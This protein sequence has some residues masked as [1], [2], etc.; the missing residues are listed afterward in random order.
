MLETILEIAKFLIPSLIV[1]ATAYYLLNS[2]LENQLKLRQVEA[3]MKKSD[4]V[5]GQVLPI[6]L[7]AYERLVCLLYTSDA[8]DE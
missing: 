7:Q 3:Q 8:A 2:Y 1:F 5:T 4:S 6:R